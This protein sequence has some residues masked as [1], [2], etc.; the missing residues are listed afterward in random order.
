M[1]CKGGIVE[2]VSLSVTSAAGPPSA[3]QSALARGLVVQGPQVWSIAG[4]RHRISLYLARLYAQ[5]GGGVARNT[6]SASGCT[7]IY[8]SAGK[9]CPHDKKR[10]SLLESR[11][12]TPNYRPFSR[13]F[14]F[15]S[16]GGPT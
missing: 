4:K 16:L 1:Q 12:L 7:G 13:H 14:N 10:A 8:F 11:E 2:A 5:R 3:L 15:I 6:S 9:N